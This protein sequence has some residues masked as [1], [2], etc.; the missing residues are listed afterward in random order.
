MSG[1]LIREKKLGRIGILKREG[2]DWKGGEKRTFQ[3]RGKV[4]E[5]AGRENCLEGE[6]KKHPYKEKKRKQSTGCLW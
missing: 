2:L 1:A 3:Q 6:E 4:I 5:I